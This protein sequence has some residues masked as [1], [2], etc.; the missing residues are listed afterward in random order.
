MIDQ[1]CLI[2]TF[3]S[4][5]NPGR[6]KPNPALFNTVERLRRRGYD[7]DARY[8]FPH[9]NDWYFSGVLGLDHSFHGSAARIRALIQ[10]YDRTIFVGNSMGGYA[11]IAFGWLSGADL[12]IAFSPQTRFG[13][14]DHR[15]I[16]EHRW[17]EA[18]AEMRKAFNV[19]QFDLPDALAGVNNSRTVM[20]VF[21]GAE[22]RQDVAYA[23]KLSALPSCEIQMVNGSGHDCAY[24]LRERGELDLIFEAALS[25]R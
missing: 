13:V 9:R 24:D 20:R 8:L 12:V 14:E 16:K 2:V 23:E 15:A 21:C 22:C 10:D 5:T 1:K 4:F 17:S 19:K 18:F 7:F 6:D 3:A 25:S 11:A